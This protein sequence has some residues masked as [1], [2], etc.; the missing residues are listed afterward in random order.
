MRCRIWAIALSLLVSCPSIGVPSELETSQGK[1][2]ISAVVERLKGPWAFA[3]LPGGELLIT[4]KR[5]KLLHVNASGK[6]SIVKGLPAIHVKGQGGLLDVIVANDF[7]QSRNVFFSYV[8]KQTG[9][10]GTAVMRARLSE[11]RKTL[12]NQRKIFEMTAGSSGGRHFGSR[13]VHAKDGSLFVTIGERGDRPE[14][15]NL[16]RHEGTIVRIS[17]EGA[18]LSNNPFLETKGAQKEIWSFGHRNPQG[19]ALDLSG[20]LWAVEHGAKGG[21]EL[22]LIRKGANYGWPVISFG[23]HYSGLKIGEGTSK[24]GLQQPNF[25]WD[26]SIAPSGLMVYSGKLWPQWKGHFFVG[27]LKFDYISRL[28][29]TPLKEREK[30]QGMSTKRVRDVREG[31]FGRIWFLSEDKGTLYRMAPGG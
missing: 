23:T 7:V 19:L 1:V 12:T 26:P 8:T 30:L 21:D 22:N 14:A 17:P 20:R 25:Y 24:A 31:P 4:E 6:R 5:G 27:S 18:I 10:S 16:A 11:D 29:G 15:Q 3:F 13:I 28:S 9:G 2:H